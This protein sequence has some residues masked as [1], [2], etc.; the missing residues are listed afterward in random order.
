MSKNINADS[1]PKEMNAE[2]DSTSNEMSQEKDSTPKGA[3]ITEGLFPD[4][5][6]EGQEV[7]PQEPP[8]SVEAKEPKPDESLEFLNLGEISDK[9][10]KVKIDGEERVI[11]YNDLVKGYQ[12][13]Q[14][15]SK[16]GK[17]LAEKEKA[18]K[19]RE[20]QPN[21]L[22]AEETVAD[23]IYGDE[24]KPLKEEIADLRN[25]L[26]N[27]APVIGDIRYQEDL[28]V[29]DGQ[30]KEEGFDDFMKFVPKIEMEIL[31]KPIEEQP[32]FKTFEHYSA[33]FKDY[34]LKEL[35]DAHKE[36]DKPNLNPEERPKPNLVSIEG[37][38][39]AP[40]GT[41][42]DPA[43]M[44]KLMVEAGETGDWEKVLAEKGY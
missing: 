27:I 14:H 6:E 31:E 1:T 4:L 26:K 29:L 11:T 43:K 25:Q 23:E 5:V 41:P 16:K 20:V 8:Q 10:V 18:L 3:N 42:A 7:V 38:G 33:K 44:A 2:K 40:T 34:K 28:K 15:L 21:P 37:G 24:L 32:Q 36:K 13:D 9:K 19:D 22:P 17:A 12:T 39:G 30:M 35:R